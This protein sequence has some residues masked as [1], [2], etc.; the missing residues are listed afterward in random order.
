MDRTEAFTSSF[1]TITEKT[2]KI[3]KQVDELVKYHLNET[4]N[5]KFKQS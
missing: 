2:N 5:P 4:A 1:A 3:K